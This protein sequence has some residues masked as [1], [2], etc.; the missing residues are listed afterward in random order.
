VLSNGEEVIILAFRRRTLLP[1]DDCL[2]AP[3]A[4]ISHLTRSSLARCQSGMGWSVDSLEVPARPIMTFDF[5]A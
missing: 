4:T 2:Y 5:C 1:L 3:L